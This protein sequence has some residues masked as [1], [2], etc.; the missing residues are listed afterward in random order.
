MLRH[1]WDREFVLQIHKRNEQG[2][3]D[4]SS[5]LHPSDAA[6]HRP[7]QLHQVVDTM[8][9]SWGLPGYV[10]INNSDNSRMNLKSAIVSI[11][12]NNNQ[13]MSNI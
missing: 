3:W 8:R 6:P 5:P 7:H 1:S 4:W 11:F 10:T 12:N 13:Q 9:H 2:E